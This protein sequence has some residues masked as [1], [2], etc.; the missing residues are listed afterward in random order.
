M[1]SH[2]RGTLQKKNESDLSVEIDVGGIWYKVYLPAFVWRA[3]EDVQTGETIEFETFYY[4]AERQPVPKLVGFKR[5]I[6]RQ[7]FEKFINVPSLGPTRALKALAFSVS[8]IAQWIES[9]DV[10]SLRQ[11]PEVGPRMA[12]SI[13]AHLK[14]RVIEEALLKDEA[15]T[16]VPE[17][18]PSTDDVQRDAIAGL[19]S[20]GYARGEAERLVNEIA[21]DE[22]ALTVEEI[23]RAVFR[24]VQQRI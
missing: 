8:T 1:I 13:V 20:L 9:G 17:A 15:F 24:R 5:D 2:I 12:S 14:G 19:V 3:I 16:S 6:E 10:A 22:A 18:S 11:L 23:I 4:V 21:R 7:F